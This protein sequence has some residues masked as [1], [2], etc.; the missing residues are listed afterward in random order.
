MINFNK[1]QCTFLI[2][3]PFVTCAFQHFIIFPYIEKVS[4]QIEFSHFE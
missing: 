3:L 4:F 2:G 1:C